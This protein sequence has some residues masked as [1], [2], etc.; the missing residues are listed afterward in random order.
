MARGRAGG[1]VPAAGGAGHG[2]SVGGTRAAAARGV[3]PGT[4]TA[5]PH[6]AGSATT[7]A[8]ALRPWASRQQQDSAW[9][10]CR[11]ASWSYRGVRNQH[12]EEPLPSACFCFHPLKEGGNYHLCKELRGLWLTAVGNSWRCCRA[13]ERP[14]QALAPP[15]VSA[16]NG[17]GAGAASNI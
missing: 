13:S 4:A 8:P 16:A 10:C 15:E 9:L 14:W 7:R 17:L 12:L 2:R 6:K 3:Q 11:A 1:I 5:A